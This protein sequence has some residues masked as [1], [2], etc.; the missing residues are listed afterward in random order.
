MYIETGTL[1]DNIAVTV[2]LVFSL[3]V[4]LYV[5]NFRARVTL[6]PYKTSVNFAQSNNSFY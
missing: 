6:V 4:A 5:A 3:V 2:V 1:G